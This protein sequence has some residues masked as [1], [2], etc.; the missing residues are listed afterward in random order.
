M[1]YGLWFRVQGLG[2]G[3]WGLGFRVSGFGFRVSGFGFWVSGFGFRDG[4]SLRRFRGG[5]ALKAHRLVYHSTLGK[6]VIKK[7]KKV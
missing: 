7:E 3:V 1:V 5:L 4:T 2:S 6:R